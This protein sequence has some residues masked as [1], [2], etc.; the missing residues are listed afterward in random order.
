MTDPLFISS[1]TRIAAILCGTVGSLTDLRSRRIPNWL[2]GPAMLLGI[3]LHLLGGGWK[4]GTSALSALLLCGAV[5]FVFFL[6]GGMGAGD[7]KL[8]AAE[9]SLLGLPSSGSLLLYTVLCGGVL[10]LGLALKRGKFRSTLANVL[11]LILHH[12]RNGLQP[13]P[14]LN[15]LNQSTLRLPYGVAIALGC[16]LTLCLR[17]ITGLPL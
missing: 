13:H 1:A 10:G 4:G 15:V 11:R 7:V 17:P 9:A 14:E 12:G 16:L 2:T 6:A 3:S 5:F 8:I